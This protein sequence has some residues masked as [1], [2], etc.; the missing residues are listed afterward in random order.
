MHLLRPY[1][2]ELLGSLLHRATRQLGLSQSRL[3]MT[4]SGATSTSFPMVITRHSGFAKACGMDFEEFLQR[5]SLLPYMLAFLS[6]VDRDRIQSTVIAG[7][8]H[9]ASTASAAQN[10]TKTT[11]KLRFCRECV[12]ADLELYGDAYWHRS[13]QLP[14]VILCVVHSCALYVSDIGIRTVR[15]VAPPDK[16][17]GPS[18]DTSTL[19]HDV[20]QRITR[21][22]V[23][24]LNGELPQHDWTAYYTDYAG[25]MGYGYKGWQVIGEVLS[26]DL[27][28]YY[29]K[30]HLETLDLAFEPR[31]R[32]T[33][34][35]LMVRSSML[36][37]TALKHVL[38]NVFLESS[39]TP[40]RKPADI[41]YRKKAQ[42]RDWPRIERDLIAKLNVEHEKLKA[43]GDRAMVRSL[44]AA[45]GAVQI[46]HHHRKKVPNLHAWIE[47]F[48]ITPQAE[49]QIGKRPRVYKKRV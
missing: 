2:D 47:A 41:M 14:G 33:W 25:K 28:S 13:H 35:A 26:T 1:P 22:S 17:D 44:V 42:P 48:K 36:N 38:L 43:S 21:F 12:A 16:V 32:N 11:A 27:L 49:R 4:L 29:G 23:A 9:P 39:P 40:S 10:A 5:H 8:G 19:P 37:S 24:A 3:M 34:P 46:L 15:A 7:L 45:V 31:K 30:A 18:A 20:L 6:Q